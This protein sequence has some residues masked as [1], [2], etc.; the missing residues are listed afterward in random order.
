MIPLR[1]IEKEELHNACEL[2]ISRWRNMEGIDVHRL[3]RQERVLREICGVLTTEGNTKQSFVI[4]AP[5]GFGKTILGFMVMDMFKTY[6][7]LVGEES[8]GTGYIMTSN[9]FLQEQYNND[10]KR[11]EGMD[12]YGLLKGMKN[13]TCDLN[14]NTCDARACKDVSFSRIPSSRKYSECCKTCKYIQA[15]NKAIT[16]NVAVLNYNYFL[17]AMNYVYAR[18]QDNSP[19]F[20]RMVSIYDECDC[21]PKMVQ[22][23]FTFRNNLSKISDDLYTYY[24][25]A[26]NQFSRKSMDDEPIYTEKDSCEMKALREVIGHVYPYILGISRKDTKTNGEYKNIAT[27]LGVCADRLRQAGDILSRCIEATFPEKAD[28][29]SEDH[30][31]YVTF[32]ESIYDKSTAC[33]SVSEAFADTPEDMVI[34]SEKDA[35]GN[36]IFIIRNVNELKLVQKHLLE[37]TELS[38][39]MSATITPEAYARENGIEHYHAICVESDFDL[40]KSPILF[41]SPQRKLSYTLKEANFPL[42]LAECDNII[43]KHKNHNGLVHTGSREFQDRFV[44]HLVSSGYPTG[45][46]LICEN[47]A[48]KA[49][50]I[51]ELI[52]RT[53]RGE[54]GMLLIGYS[55]LEGVDLKYD[56][57]RF[58][59]CLK[60]PYP[61]MADELVKRKN[62]RFPKWYNAV[63]MG[64]FLQMAGR[65]VRA[66]DDWAYIYLVDGSYIDLFKRCETLHPILK[67]RIHYVSGENGYYVEGQTDEMF[68]FSSYGIIKEIEIPVEDEAVPEFVN[69]NNKTESFRTFRKT[70]D[71]VHSDDD[72]LPF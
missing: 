57:A 29:Y 51:N 10:I 47:A 70:F 6:R 54:R 59:I 20:P 49:S 52:R 12:G 67:N 9:I 2:T 71:A 22:E 32:T 33:R 23:M 60:A 1:E 7:C 21:V 72:D 11:F 15:R 43:A 50:N 58:C 18:L 61:S 39:F 69:R 38:I 16:G 66:K 17:T 26:Y 14:G 53:N 41:L 55:L 5:T 48:D 40:P 65:P 31:R 45:K 62:E 64:N 25:Q 4:E 19:Y 34:H 56:L 44:Q 27:L 46:L 8:S 28:D 35:N 37:F 68:E 30:E 36:D 24:S 63:A 3:T 42:Q 13:Y